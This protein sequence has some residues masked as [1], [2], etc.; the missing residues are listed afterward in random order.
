MPLVVRAK[1]YA[2]TEYLRRLDV[3]SYDEQFL[4]FD[5]AGVKQDKGNCKTQTTIPRREKMMLSEILFLADSFIETPGKKMTEEMY[6]KELKNVTTKLED[7]EKTNDDQIK[8]GRSATEQVVVDDN[9][10]LMVNTPHEDKTPLEIQDTTKMDQLK[11]HQTLEDHYGELAEEVAVPILNKDNAVDNDGENNNDTGAM[12]EPQRSTIVLAN[13][14]SN[15]QVG[16]VQK[17][18]MTVRKAKLNTLALSDIVA[19]GHLKMIEL[20]IPAIRHRCKLR[21]KRQLKALQLELDTYLADESGS[22]KFNWIM[23]T[24]E[25]DLLAS[26]SDIRLEYRQMKKGS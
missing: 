14:E 25:K 5:A 7:E 6:W 10:D 18:K 11:W 24:L 3:D 8:D 17:K 16:K 12:D 19:K 1:K 20:D 13:N 2:E 4:E 15:I 23:E 22:S 9:H 26:T 21:Q